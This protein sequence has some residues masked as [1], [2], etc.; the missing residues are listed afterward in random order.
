MNSID[1]DL[2]DHVCK[3]CGNLTY[4]D[5][6]YCKIGKHQTKRGFLH[7]GKLKQCDGFVKRQSNNY[8]QCK[9]VECVFWCR[10]CS[11]YKNK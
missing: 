6:Y 8:P 7:R 1:K 10:E 5:W 11:A 4:W 9:E 3:T 2:S